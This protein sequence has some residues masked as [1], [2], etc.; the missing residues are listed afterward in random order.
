[1]V[2]FIREV[3]ISPSCFLHFSLFVSWSSKQDL[4]HTAFCCVW[5]AMNN[6]H[7]HL[8]NNFICHKFDIAP[9]SFGSLLTGLRNSELSEDSCVTCHRT[10]VLPSALLC[11]VFRFLSI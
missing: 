11:P 1:M 10:S 3:V 7:A 6:L 8:F 5:T 9:C 4:K 2:T